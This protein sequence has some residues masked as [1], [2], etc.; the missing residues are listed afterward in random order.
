VFYNL[1]GFA[2]GSPFG[3]IRAIDGNKPHGGQDYVAPPGTK[4]PAALDGKV[5]YVG[6]LGKFPRAEFGFSDKRMA[7]L[8]ARGHG[9]LQFV[10]INLK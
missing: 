4:A 8:D 9:I 6:H 3:A 7:G 10:P 1:P 2:I 5:Y